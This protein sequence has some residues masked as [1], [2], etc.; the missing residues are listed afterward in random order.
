M[1]AVL[2]T[3]LKPFETASRNGVSFLILVRKGIEELLTIC[4]IRTNP[5][6]DYQEQSC[7]GEG[8]V[9][10]SKRLNVQIVH[11][12]CECQ[13]V[14]QTVRDWQVDDSENLALFLRCGVSM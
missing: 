5:F 9:D 14:E 2:G 11:G 1:T 3:Y 10:P 8:L 6:E 12:E 13:E 4:A 7:D